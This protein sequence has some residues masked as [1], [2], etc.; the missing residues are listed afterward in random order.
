MNTFI[1]RFLCAGTLLA[2]ALLKTN[3]LFTDPGLGLLYGSRWRDAAL[4]EYELALALWLLSGFRLRSARRLALL[5]FT[6]FGAYAL[7][8]GVSGESS[9][10]CFGKASVNPWWTVALDALL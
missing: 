7:Y 4:A 6:T 9:C 1:P 2:A 8:L 5:T 3:Q 10:G